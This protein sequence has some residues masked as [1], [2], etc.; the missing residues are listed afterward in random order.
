MTI[1]GYT[2]VTIHR[3]LAD[4][5]WTG[6]AL[7]FAASAIAAPP[8]DSDFFERQI[9]PL[10]I[11]S[12]IKCHGPKKQS[13]KLRLDSRDVLL[14]G[15]ESGPAIVPTAPNK[16]LL[17]SAVR[18]TGN[19]EM[20]PQEKLSPAQVAALVQWIQMGA[21]W[22]DKVVL[23]LPGATRHWAFQPVRQQPIPMVSHGDLVRTPIDAF[24]L[25]KLK[26]H[27]LTPSPPMN[28]RALIH[29]AT[30]DLHGL[31]PT[32]DEVE[33]FVRD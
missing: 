10:L 17:I 29:R 31:P 33:T 30:F 22:P 20:P 24:V 25:A 2:R 27:G 8:A 28:R 7:L 11:E 18:R 12:C 19:L 6:I 16:S 1:N 26:V 21:K 15:G 32:L 4:V 23:N 5:R 9:R 3:R 13:G 14:R